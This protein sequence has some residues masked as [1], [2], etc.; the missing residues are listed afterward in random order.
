[1]DLLVTMRRP[2]DDRIAREEA[3]RSE[4]HGVWPIEE[5]WARS[6]GLPEVYRDTWSAIFAL[7]PNTPA[8]TA[9]QTR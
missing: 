5:R 7:R 1:V 2:P 6:L 3:E 4:R 8:A 9:G